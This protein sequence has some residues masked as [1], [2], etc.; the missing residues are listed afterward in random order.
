MLRPTN[1]HHQFDTGATYLDLPPPIA[2]GIASKFIPPAISNPN[3]GFGSYSVPCN[4]TAP[5]FGVQIG[6]VIFP[7]DK[8]DMIVSDQ[9]GEGTCQTGTQNLLNYAPYTLG[10][11]FMNNVLSVFDVGSGEMKIRAR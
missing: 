9:T 3:I 10:D 5:W 7:V 8:K 4:A 11:T 6:G 2:D 1:G